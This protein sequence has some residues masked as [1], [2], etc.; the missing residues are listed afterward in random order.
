MNAKHIDKI[1]LAMTSQSKHKTPTK[2]PVDMIVRLTAFV[3]E[4]ST[5]L[6]NREWRKIGHQK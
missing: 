4:S 3:R 1:G 2:Q 6:C 5:T